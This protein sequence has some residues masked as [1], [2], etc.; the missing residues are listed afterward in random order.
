VTTTAQRLRQT[1]RVTADGVVEYGVSVPH[2]A[3]NIHGDTRYTASTPHSA[4]A[5]QYRHNA[6]IPNDAWIGDRKTN[7]LGVTLPHDCANHLSL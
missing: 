2:R 1:V 5:S 6:G 3:A 4:K 7:I